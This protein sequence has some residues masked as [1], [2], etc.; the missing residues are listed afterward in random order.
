MKVK[1]ASIISRRVFIWGA[2]GNHN[3]AKEWSE[4]LKGP[5][6]VLCKHKY[7]QS[8]SSSTMEHIHYVGPETDLKPSV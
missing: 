8:H 5:M 3:S 4:D 7:F 6:L 2:K 1:G